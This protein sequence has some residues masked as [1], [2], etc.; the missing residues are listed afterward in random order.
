MP[1]RISEFSRFVR[2][3]ARRFNQDRCM[4]IASS[5]TYTT[6][7]ALVPL[8]TV[9]LTLISAFPVFEGWTRQLQK[10]LLENLLPESA[11]LMARYGEQFTANAAQ[12]TAVGIAFLAVT[13]IL[14][15]LTIEHAFNQIWRVQ[16]TRTTVQRIFI[17]WALLTIGPVL[18]GASLSLTSWLVSLSVGLVRE[19]PGAGVGLL[20]I[21]PVVLI[22]LALTLLYLAMPNRRVLIRDAAAGGLLAAL[23]FEG[24]KRGFTFYITQF[25][26]YKLVYGAFASAPIFLLWVYLS[27]L[28]VLT[29]A[30]IV[31]VLP[32]WRHQSWQGESA[33]GTQFFDAL[34]ILGLLW[35]GHREGGLCT[36]R[37]L[38]ATVKL[39]V[40]QIEWMLDTM[41]AA[42][43]IG[44]VGAGWALIRDP[45]EIRV[46]DVYRLFVFRGGPRIT[47]RET[48]SQID[49]YAQRLAAEVEEHMQMS[50]EELFAEGKEK[51]PALRA[52]APNAG[53]EHLERRSASR[54]PS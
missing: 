20:R 32:E 53:G 18:I 40:D 50:L 39:R 34:H 7:L 26:T 6:L 30:I 22:W 5:L 24:M 23:A 31:A 36:L 17:Y 33:P 16:R 48:T 1:R 54:H 27:W 9:A 2:A 14:M 10:F 49:A 41:S 37:H 43:W 38:H 52:T 21:V 44:Q 42:Q 13:A 35:K 19:I 3:V 28:V 15:L 46:A 11:H 25:P 45:R 12:L 29:G 51:V 47:G 4:Q 8:I